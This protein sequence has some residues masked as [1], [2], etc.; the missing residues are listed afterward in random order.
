MAGAV[1]AAEA[2]LEIGVAAEV[3]LAQLP[4]ECREMPAGQQVA[5]A[6]A[7]APPVEAPARLAAAIGRRRVHTQPDH[8]MTA[9]VAAEAEEPA[10]AVAS[11]AAMV[12]AVEVDPCAAGCGCGEGC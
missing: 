1:T 9:A 2:L 12:V 11:E 7:A 4:T 10:L 5:V 3:A 8:A 6:A